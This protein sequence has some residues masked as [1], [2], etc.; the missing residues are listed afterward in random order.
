[1]LSTW[2]MK[3]ALGRLGH[4]FLQCASVSNPFA[5]EMRVRKGLGLCQNSCLNA[6]TEVRRH[7]GSDARLRDW[8]PETAAQV[9]E[10]IAAVIEFAHADLLELVR[11]R[12]VEQAMLDL[13]DEPGAR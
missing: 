9:R 2:A 3:Y 1:M 11:S 6:R 5:T 13:L 8:R 7:S 12:A 4:G 10:R